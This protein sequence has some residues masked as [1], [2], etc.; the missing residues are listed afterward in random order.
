MAV[1]RLVGAGLLR[2]E[3]T[4]RGPQPALRHRRVRIERTLEGDFLEVRR[5]QAHH[6]KQIRILCLRRH[7]ELRRQRAGELHRGFPRGSQE[8]DTIP[9]PGINALL[10]LGRGLGRQRARARFQEGL[11][12][13][14]SFKRPFFFGSGYEDFAGMKALL[15]WE[16]I[17]HVVT[18]CLIRFTSFGLYFPADTVLQ[19]TIMRIVLGIVGSWALAHGE[20][21]GYDEMV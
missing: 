14:G 17:V 7:E 21:N 4:V 8:R 1:I 12:P 3:L 15:T 5:K 6:Q 13:L 16:V 18:E 19:G 9:Q 20:P 2:I 11:G 10:L